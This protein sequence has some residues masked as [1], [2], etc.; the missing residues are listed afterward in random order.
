MERVTL[1]RG[2]LAGALV[3]LVGVVCFG[4]ALWNWGSEGFGALDPMTTMRL[5]ILGMLFVV[6][7]FQLVLVS[8][9]LS[10]A[11]IGRP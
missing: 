9:T 7:G 8:F 5:P 3:V 4:W 1:D 6:G 11:R 2:L 10:L